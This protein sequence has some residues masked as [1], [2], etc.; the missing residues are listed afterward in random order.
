ML[1]KVFIPYLNC[2]FSAIMF[3]SSA[4]FRRQCRKPVNLEARHKIHSR[5]R[6]KFIFTAN[7][8]SLATTQL[9]LLNLDKFC[10]KSIAYTR[11]PRGRST[12]PWYLKVIYDKNVYPPLR[13]EAV[14]RCKHC[15]GTDNNYRCVTVYAEMPVLHR[16]GEYILKHG[17]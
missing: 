1:Y 5:L 3:V 17:Y 8:A 12:C 16:T 6:N 15:L 14:C 11:A 4:S 9:P 10:P 13:T 2:I 7:I